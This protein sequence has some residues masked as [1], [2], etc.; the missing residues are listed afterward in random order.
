M[1]KPGLR[2]GW[3]WR[4]LANEDL[5]MT[6]VRRCEAMRR[7]FQVQE[8]SLAHGVCICGGFECFL[9]VD[10]RWFF[11]REPERTWLVSLGG[12]LIRG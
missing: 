3:M 1:R 8:P 12:E 7:C 2:L 9:A 10:C 5:W 11:G 6:P 4:R